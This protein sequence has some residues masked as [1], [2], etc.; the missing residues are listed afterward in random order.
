MAEIINIDHEGGDLSGYDSTVVDGGDLS[1]SAA[2]ALGGSYGLQCVIDDTTAIYGQKS[3]GTW[4]GSAV[5]MRLRFYIH[6]NGLTMANGDQFFVCNPSG[7]FPFTIYLRYSAGNYQ[8]HFEYYADGGGFVDSH[9]TNI[10]NAK[11]Y[12]ELLVRRAASAVSGD[13]SVQCWVDRSLEDTQS[14]IDNYDFFNG[15]GAL[16]LGAPGSIDAGTSGIFYL[17]EFV[18]RNDDTEIG[19]LPAGADPAS[20]TM[21]IALGLGL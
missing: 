1:V 14:G 20:T 5:S 4:P 6:P 13:G 10:T 18:V 17:D 19:P 21:R 7:T 12:I 15:M 9:N 8:A 11:H 2:A 3:L 16:R